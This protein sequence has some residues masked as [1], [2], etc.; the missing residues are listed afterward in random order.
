MPDATLIAPSIRVDVV[1]SHDIAPAI[2]LAY[3]EFLQHLRAAGGEIHAEGFGQLL[4]QIRLIEHLD[5][6]GVELVENLLRRPGRRED[7]PPGERREAAKTLLRESG[8]VGH[9]VRALVA[10]QGERAQLS[11]LHVRGERRHRPGPEVNLAANHAAHHRS[12]ALVGNVG[13]LETARLLQEDRSEVAEA[14][15]ADRADAERLRL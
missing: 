11:A 4:A 1:A 12:A 9:G 8:H 5:Q 15:V 7:A 10:G 2:D 3:E 13:N 6:L 14:A